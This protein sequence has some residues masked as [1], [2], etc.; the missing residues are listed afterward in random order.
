MKQNASIR[1]LIRF[2]DVG[3]LARELQ[4]FPTGAAIYAA[5]AYLTP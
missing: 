5:A 1:F 2:E 3:K 4:A